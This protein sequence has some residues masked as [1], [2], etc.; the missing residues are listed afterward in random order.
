MSHHKWVSFFGLGFACALAGCSA[1]NGSATAEDS[2]ASHA[3]IGTT[4]QA[5][6]QATAPTEASMTS[7][8]S[9]AIAPTTSVLALIVSRDQR[10]C[11]TPLCGGYIIR[12]L[13]IG[14]N[15]YVSGIDFSAIDPTSKSQMTGAAD[16]KL[17]MN[18]TFSRPDPTFHTQQFIAKT[19]YRGMPGITP[20]SGEGFYT[21]A[22]RVPPIECLVAPC[23][24]EIA[25]LV[26]TT[27]T[28][29]FDA[30]SVA[31]ASAPFV[32]Q[33]WL[34]ERVRHHGAVVSAAFV[35]GA[36]QPCGLETILDSSQVFIRLPYSD[37][38]CPLV[39][40]RVCDP[41]GVYVYMR[42]VDRCLIPDG[43][44][45]PGVCPLFMPSCSAGYTLQSWATL[46]NACPAYACD[47]T[48][49]VKF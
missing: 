1:S 10:L 8:S 13:N 30:F 31:R 5:A 29:A 6:S 42:S 35:S 3:E 24:N 15:Q 37:G 20:A 26:N 47:P 46:P 45:V 2:Q 22:D 32:D 40:I 14:Q 41:P 23:P 18:G 17:V 7:A 38:P 33:P 11:P 9:T 34:T 19:M 39:P 43:C 27:K 12:V 25:T 48:F 44:V 36:Q 16:G 28:T 21:A 49:T 4:A